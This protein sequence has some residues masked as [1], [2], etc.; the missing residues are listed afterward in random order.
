MYIC[1]HVRP[2]PEVRDPELDTEELKSHSQP[3]RSSQVRGGIKKVVLLGGA[4]HKVAYPPPQLWSK[5]HFFG[6]GIF[7]A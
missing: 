7:F 6:G 1:M 2:I 3:L 5:Y 4:H